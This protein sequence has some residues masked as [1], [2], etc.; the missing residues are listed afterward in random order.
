MTDDAELLRK[1]VQA[2]SEDAFEEL[3]QR[4]L[5]VVY[6]SALRQ[7]D[8]DVELA[9]DICQTVF[10]DLARKAG[11][12]LG[13][14]LLIG[15]LFS[16]TRFAAAT[17]LRANRRRQIRERIAVSMQEDAAAPALECRDPKLAST[18]DAAMEELTSEDRNAVLLRFF[19]GKSLKDVA[20]ALGINDDAARMRVNRALDRLH[21]LLKQ[22]G[23]TLSA[24][25]VGTAL[26]AEAVIAV[27]EGLAASVAA[28]A[29]SSAA[30]GGGISLTL[31]K[32]ATMTK[33][34]ACI[35]GV[36]VVAGLA[37][38]LIVQNQSI[39]RLREESR[40]LREQAGQLAQVEAENERLSN[41]LAQAKIAEPLPREQMSELLR[42]RGEVTQL[43]AQ[44]LERLS[45]AGTGPT[46]P[47]PLAAD[48][49]RDSVVE[50]PVGKVWFSNAALSQVLDVYGAIA[51]AN[52]VA[53][54]GVRLPAALITFS[55]RQDLTHSE[56]LHLF[57]DAFRDQAGLVVEYQDAK[58]FTARPDIT[59]PTT[60]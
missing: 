24:A 60:K 16:A 36:L 37:V 33:L 56:A 28:T 9:K 17:V 34:Q 18:L 23:V 45:S 55:N 13:H 3:V 11:S 43:R 54:P 27:P 35:I 39:A 59:V 14:E 15:W 49:S 20:T 32:I 12:L 50:I 6:S 42:L 40:A 29:V 5:P 51:G 41:L 48:P 46:T 58:H 53:E 10:I 2:G 44:R 38:L 1:Y 8:G 30:T 52:L 22:R 47:A 26:T 19:Q 25:A 57:E 7:T 21:G 4:H 31:L